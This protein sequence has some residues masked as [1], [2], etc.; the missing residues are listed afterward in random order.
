MRRASSEVNSRRPR[1]READHH[2]ATRPGFGAEQ[3]DRHEHAGAVAGHARL[4]GTALDHVDLERLE[5]VAEQL[6]E[7]IRRAL[8]LGLDLARDAVQLLEHALGRQ[9]AAA[10]QLIQD[11]L[12]RAPSTPPAR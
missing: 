8:G 7:Q 4:A 5:Q 3:R 10:A 2:R 12:P 11:P 9:A 1:L 6:R